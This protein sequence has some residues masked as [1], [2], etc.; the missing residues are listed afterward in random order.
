MPVLSLACH[1]RHNTPNIPSRYNNEQTTK[2]TKAINN[3][4]IYI[5]ISCKCDT[6]RA[7]HFTL[8]AYAS[9][10]VACYAS[11][12]TSSEKNG[13]HF[14]GRRNFQMHFI[15]WKVLYFDSNFTELCWQWVT[16]ASGNGWAPKRRQVI[17]WTNADPVHRRIYATLGGLNNQLAKPKVVQW[18][19]TMPISYHTKTNQIISISYNISWYYVTSYVHGL[20]MLC[21]IMT[22]QCC[23]ALG[24]FFTTIFPINTRNLACKGVF[25]FNPVQFKIFS[26]TGVQSMIL[27]IHL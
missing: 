16:I 9:R 7:G 14:A 24:Y 6:N 5:N 8:D 18:R 23:P 22:I 21:F 19:Y 2:Q 12:N 11:F 15:E 17:I 3:S 13:R 20:F 26:L 25:K 4:Y 27:F 10:P 1:L